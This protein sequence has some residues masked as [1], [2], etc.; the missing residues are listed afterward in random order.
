MKSFLI[1]SFLCLQ[2]CFVFGIDEAGCLAKEGGCYCAAAKECY[3]R[4][5]ETVFSYDEAVT[6]CKAKGAVLPHFSV[7]KAFEVKECK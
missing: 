3:I 2:L 4:A 5:K 6:L 7:Q 1:L